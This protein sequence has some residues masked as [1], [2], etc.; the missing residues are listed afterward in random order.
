MVLKV[1]QVKP[2]SYSAAKRFNGNFKSNGTRLHRERNFRK[3]E[4]AR[5]GRMADMLKQLNG[6]APDLSKLTKKGK[7]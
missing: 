4:Y 5:Y 3:Y 6:K 2:K 7:K 1:L